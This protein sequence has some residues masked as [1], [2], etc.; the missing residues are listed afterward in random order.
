M[1]IAADLGR[2]LAYLRA[3]M[4][5]DAMEEVRCRVLMGCCAAAFV[6]AYAAPM[7]GC[8]SDS[9]GSGG[10][11]GGAEDASSPD[12]V[13]DATAMEAG[14]GAGGGGDPG[15]ARANR[16]GFFPDCTPCGADC[17]TIDDGSGS[18]KACGC[19]GG[20]PCGLHCGSYQIAP[21]VFVSDI[22]VR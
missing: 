17:D 16:N 1:K 8:S 19:S 12:A 7:V 5:G 20:C 14:S 4:V 11:A 13:E 9:G 3:V 10:S 21:G 15:C 6:L 2:E 22:C 18:S